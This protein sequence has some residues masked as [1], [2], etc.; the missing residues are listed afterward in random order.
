MLRRG[1]GLR[2]KLHSSAAG[3]WRNGPPIKLG[4]RPAL[5]ASLTFEVAAALE[6]LLLDPL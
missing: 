1:R 5:P 3:A 6:W 4:T 2:E